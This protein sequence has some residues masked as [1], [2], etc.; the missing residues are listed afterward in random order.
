MKRFTI[1]VALSLSL[2]AAI[3]A[4]QSIQARNSANEPAPSAAASN[5]TRST[6]RAIHLFFLSDNNGAKNIGARVKLYQMSE[7]C[8][9]TQVSPRKHFISG[10]R[11][12]FG[13]ESNSKGYLYV[14]QKGS[15][16]RYTLL[17]KEAP[18]RR[19]TELLIPGNKSWFRF[20]GTPGVED[21]LFIVSRDRLDILPM[22]VP[23]AVSS[24]ANG[25]NS[26]EGQIMSILQGRE[27]RDLVLSS[28]NDTENGSPVSND[29]AYSPVYA[30]NSSANGKLVSIRLRLAH[31]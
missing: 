1:P 21:L 6:D 28:D 19:G 9:L 5:A 27:S 24:P 18:V 10:E 7:A 14:V 29:D 31:D 8:E 30:V 12:R 4:A 17:T 22:L 20:D 13:F 25:G 23:D 26:T 11:L 2:C 15:S 16:G 3:A